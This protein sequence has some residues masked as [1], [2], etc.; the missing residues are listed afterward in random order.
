MITQFSLLMSVYINTSYEELSACFDSIENQSA[1]PAEV[2][3]VV[4]GEIRPDVRDALNQYQ[5]AL[6]IKILEFE[7]NRG[8]GLALG[9]G[10]KCCENELVARMDTDDVCLPERFSKQ[11]KYFND[12][13]QVSVLGGGLTEVY[14]LKGAHYPR[15]REVVINVDEFYK[16]ALYRN[17][18]NHQ[19]VMFKKS[20]VLAVGNYQDMQWFEDYYLWARLLM[21]G[22]V[23]ANIKNSLVTTYIDDE[24]FQRR[25][26]IRY[27]LKELSLAKGFR[28]IGFHSYLQSVKFIIMRSMFRMMP[29]KIRSSM[30]RR[31]LR[32]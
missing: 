30:Y 29:T 28:K 3:V 17:P 8:L 20:A 16:V 27:I 7:V 31:L 23:L 9:D 13:E 21:A 2:V 12:N 5:I 6:N 18:L 1:K 4:D 24:Y 26:G 19:T 11:I 15:Q 32:Q 14:L 25:G 22:Y 10:L